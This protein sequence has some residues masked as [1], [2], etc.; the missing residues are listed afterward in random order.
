M[1]KIS[2]MKEEHIP[3]IHEIEK[4]C[5]SISW[6]KEAFEN[7]LKENS[8]AYYIVAESEDAVLGY[9]GMWIIVDEG[10]ITNIAVHPDFQHQGVG[11]LLMQHLI[12]EAKR[13]HFF[14]L[15]LEVRESNIKAQNLYRKF[16]FVSEGLR[17]GYYQD[18]GENAIIMWKYFK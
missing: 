3:R 1:I 10:H 14:G 8:L 13:K 4:S 12:D 2:P 16:G 11:T 9:A 18:T 5:F 6:S 15:T 7:E 17:K